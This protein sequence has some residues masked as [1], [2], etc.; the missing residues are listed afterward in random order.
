MG[1]ILSNF[2]WVGPSR[3][4]PSRKRFRVVAPIPGAYCNLPPTAHGRQ[5]ETYSECYSLCERVFCIW[6]HTANPSERG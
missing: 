2:G 4:L 3:H 1:P 6:P 5:L